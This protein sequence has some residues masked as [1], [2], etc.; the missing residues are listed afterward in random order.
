[1]GTPRLVR[2]SLAIKA[3]AGTTPNKSIEVVRSETKT[4]TAETDVVAPLPG[5][6]DDQLEAMPTTPPPNDPAAVVS[7]ALH[8]N[9]VKTKGFNAFSHHYASLT[10]ATV[11]I[12]V[13]DR[14]MTLAIVEF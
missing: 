14:V 1:V 7:L 10:A 12:L 9:S 2:Q 11:T 5:M 6:T 3:S 13:N 8:P 4:V